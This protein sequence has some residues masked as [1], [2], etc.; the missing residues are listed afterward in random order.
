[1]EEGI[2]NR[3]ELLLGKKN[4]QSI[5]NKRVI[6]FGVGGV[7]SWCAESLIRSGIHHLTIVDSDRICITNINRQLIATHS[8]LGKKKVVS[9]YER[10]K[11]IAPDCNIYTLDSFYS[12]ENPINLEKFDYVIDCIDSVRSKLFLIESAHKAGV[13]IISCMG[14]G[15]KLDPTRLEVSDISKT[16]VCPLAKVIRVELRKKGINHLK[17][18]YSKEQPVINTRTPASLPFVPPVAGFIM[19]GEVIKDIAEVNKQ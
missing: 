6:L 4:T 17:V 14:T 13:P 5:A 9:A 15:N 1:M 19:A 16:S 18:V 11:D 3:T 12:E 8:T 2:F 7:G 10:Y